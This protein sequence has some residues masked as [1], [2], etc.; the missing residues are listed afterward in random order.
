[1]RI[2]RSQIRKFLLEISAITKDPVCKKCGLM[3]LSV[4]DNELCS[5]CDKIEG[6]ETKLELL[7]ASLSPN[8]GYN[9]KTVRSHPASVD[10]RPNQ[11]GWKFS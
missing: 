9:G 8:Q 1:M 11:K 4:D 5:E 7:P 10:G 6:D 3:V 2:T